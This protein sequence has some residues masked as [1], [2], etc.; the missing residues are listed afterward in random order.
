MSSSEKR[1]VLVGMGT[2]DRRE[3][4]TGAGLG[5]FFLAGLMCDAAR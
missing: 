4:V 3:L 1:N 2:G 5:R